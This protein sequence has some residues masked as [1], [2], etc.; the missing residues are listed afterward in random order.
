MER[1]FDD[2]ADRKQKTDN[3]GNTEYI[4]QYFN[5]CYGFIHYIHA[6][7]DVYRKERK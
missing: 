6:G 3:Q 1:P 4:K 7:Y 5:R 2:A